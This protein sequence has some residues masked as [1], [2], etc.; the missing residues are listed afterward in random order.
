MIPNSVRNLY[1]GGKP[2]FI[3][4]YDGNGNEV[5]N[6]YLLQKY[7]QQPSLE[8]LE[9]KSIKNEQNPMHSIKKMRI[10]NKHAE[11]PIYPKKIEDI[12]LKY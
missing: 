11:M 12:C 9:A 8:S 7:S 2:K 3:P 6:K 1:C 4:V 10:Y 5:T